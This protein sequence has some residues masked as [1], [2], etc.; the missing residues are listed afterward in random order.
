MHIS[1]NELHIWYSFTPNY[2]FF[3][4]PPKFVTLSSV[5]HHLP[6]TY[7]QFFVFFFSFFFS[8]KGVFKHPPCATTTSIVN[9]IQ[10]THID[11]ASFITEK[12]SVCYYIYIHFTEFHSLTSLQVVT[13]TSISNYHQ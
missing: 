1:L 13:D 8:Q 11:Q 7:L 2:I 12:V 3:L 6:I 5:K 9:T 10:A 4:F